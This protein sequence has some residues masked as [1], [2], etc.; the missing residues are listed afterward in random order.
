MS[1]NIG[2]CTISKVFPD[3][4]NNSEGEKAAYAN[5]QHPYKMFSGTINFTILINSS[6]FL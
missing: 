4:R 3:K 5:K 1:G 6:R 2:T